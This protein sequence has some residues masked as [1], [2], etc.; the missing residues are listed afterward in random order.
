M[1]FENNK[2]KRSGKIFKITAN[3]T[4]V[5]GVL[6]AALLLVFPVKSPN[7]AA[8]AQIDILNVSKTNEG[9]IVYPNPKYL[10]PLGKTTGIKL[11]AK[12]AMVIGFADNAATGAKSAAEQGGLKI[13]DIITEVNGHKI[14]SNETMADAVTRASSPNMKINIMRG[15][16]NHSLNVVAE[17]DA[18]S[19]QYKIG[20]W[21]RDSLAGIGTITYVDPQNGAFGALGHGVC[22]SD[23]GSLMPIG[24]G[25]LMKSTVIGVKRGQSGTPGE[26]EGEYELTRDQ[27][28]LYQNSNSGIFGQI[29]DSDVYKEGTAI[30]VAAP[31]LLK[32]GK[33]Q[34]IA[35]ID[36][37]DTKCYD[38]E[39]VRLYN[40]ADNSMRDMMIQVTDKRLLEK[41]GGIV[42][43]M[44]G[45][46]IIQNGKLVGAVTHVLVNDPE[47][48]YG[49]RIERMIA[50]A[51]DI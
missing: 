46:P 23:T 2:N 4:A 43:G 38:I 30:E 45:S 27:G 17:K 40:G 35:N 33:A 10:I 47:R 42:Q 1:K 51:S 39:I 49:I 31:E 22:D 34:I 11:F 26:L 14:T 41:T 28:V 44:S 24:G 19:G 8:N 7:I 9:Q 13:A 21:V 3:L 16:K 48:G 50:T 25:G 5:A 18:A 6:V 32:P 20:A 29:T 15:E 12:G 37:E 36:G